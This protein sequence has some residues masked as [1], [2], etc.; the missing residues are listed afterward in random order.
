MS[1]A[2]R[3]L[4]SAGP[5]LP[6]ARPGSPSAGPGLPQPLRLA[7]AFLLVASTEVGVPF[8]AA[9]LAFLVFALVQPPDVPLLPVRALAALRVYLPF[10]VVWVALVVGW[11]HGTAA[12]GWRIPPQPL[13]RIVADQGFTAA[14]A[15]YLVGGVLVAPV[16]EEVLFRGYLLGTLRLRLPWWSAQVLT[17]ALFGLVHGRGYA[18]PIGVLGLLFGWLRQRHGALAPAIFAHAV[19]N[20]LTFA[21]TILWPGSLDLLY[22]R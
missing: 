21:V 18:L 13:L 8:E 2:D 4:P 22:P 15:I 16:V 10:V 5:G 7:I 19:H 6:S 1:D 9:I 14:T 3:A 12:L 11:L 17:A 20:A